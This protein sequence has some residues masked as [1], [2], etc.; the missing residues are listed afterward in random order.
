MFWLAYGKTCG[1]SQI[2]TFSKKTNKNH[3][4]VHFQIIMSQAAPS[5]VDPLPEPDRPPHTDPTSNQDVP[6]ALSPPSAFLQ[7]PL[8]PESC[9][10]STE[11]ATVVDT[12]KPDSSEGLTEPEAEGQLT[13]CDQPVSLEPDDAEEDVEVCSYVF[14]FS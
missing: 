10:Q 8:I 9:L 7:P 13:D 14:K 6:A 4:Y 3:G 5:D 1:D 2:I 11:E 12:T